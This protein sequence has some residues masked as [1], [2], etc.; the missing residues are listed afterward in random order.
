MSF[1]GESLCLRRDK[2]EQDSREKDNK[3]LVQE[4][5]TAALQWERQRLARSPA[6]VAKY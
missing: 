4:G 5:E 3:R 1:D 6:K 2:Y